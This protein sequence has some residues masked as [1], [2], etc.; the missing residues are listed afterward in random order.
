MFRKNTIPVALLWIALLGACTDQADSVFEPS[1]EVTFARDGEGSAVAISALTRNVYVGAD[2]S[3][4]FEVDFNNPLAVV[5]AA[6]GVWAEVQSTRFE[7]RAVVLVDE[8]EERRPHLIGLQEVARFITIDP[9]TGAP[10]ASLDFLSI[11]DAE[12]VDRGLRYEIVEVRENTRVTLPVAIDFETGMVSEAIDF[13][14]RD[15]VLARSD[16]TITNIATEQRT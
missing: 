10:T 6:A 7:E 8:V 2:L 3:P 15:V 9:A 4:I 16:V 1:S 14:D 12:M 11:L 5:Q 13:T